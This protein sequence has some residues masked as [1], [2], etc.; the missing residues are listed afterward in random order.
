MNPL[1]EHLQAH[2]IKDLQAFAREIEAFPDDSALWRAPQGI[3]NPAGNLALHVA[4]NLQFCVGA[5]LG[6]S[7][8]QRDRDGEFSRRSG[9]REEVVRELDQARR[10]VETVLPRLTDADLQKEFPLTKDGQR[11]PTDVFLLRLAV[12]LT[13]HLGQAN[14]L[15]RITAQA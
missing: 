3:A 5:L 4:G 14:Y 1:L 12:H 10:A 7:G 11:F 8:Y 15:R 6:G 9:T 2:F 13:Y